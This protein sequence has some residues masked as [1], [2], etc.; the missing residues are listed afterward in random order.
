MRMPTNQLQKTVLSTSQRY[1]TLC[2][3]STID[4]VHRASF[5]GF[6][7]ALKPPEIFGLKS[8]L[9]LKSMHLGHLGLWRIARNMEQPTRSKRTLCLVSASILL[10]VIAIY[11]WLMIML[12][13]ALRFL[14]S[15]Q[16]YVRTLLS[17]PGQQCFLSV[18]LFIDNDCLHRP[19]SHRAPLSFG[20][21]T[22][23]SPPPSVTCIRWLFAHSSHLSCTVLPLNI[24]ADHFLGLLVRVR[25]R[26]VHF[27]PLSES[28]QVRHPKSAGSETHMTSGLRP[29]LL[30]DSPL[31]VASFSS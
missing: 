11:S 21:W 12:L 29:R 19:V 15:M 26:E 3:S 28:W 23:G 31:C 24:G 10:Y 22:I 16:I 2:Y 7:P 18:T 8:S 20:M 6:C 25:T 1:A 5:Y 9:M 13:A 4:N 14:T 17:A 27:I 30:Y